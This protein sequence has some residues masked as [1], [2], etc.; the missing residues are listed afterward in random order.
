MQ[1]S[2]DT[3]S[4]TEMQHVRDLKVIF[5]LEKQALPHSYYICT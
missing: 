2:Q 4:G 5:Y 1:I 3:I